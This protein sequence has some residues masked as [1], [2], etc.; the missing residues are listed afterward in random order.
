M[1]GPSGSWFF[2]PRRLSNPRI[3]VF[4]FPY[5]GGS[6]TLFRDWPKKLPEDIELTGVQLPGRA[7]RLKDPPYTQMSSLLDELENQIGPHLDVPFVFWGHSFGAL[8]AFELVRR[9]EKK[10]RALPLLVVLSGRRAPHLPKTG[11]DVRSMDD[12]E[13]I[14][15]LRKLGGTPE[16]IINNRRLMNLVLPA[17]RADFELLHQWKHEPGETLAVPLRVAG[18]KDDTPIKEEDLE[19]WGQYTRSGFSVHMFKGGHFYVHDAE[20][21]LLPW[22]SRTLANLSG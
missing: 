9:F 16:E 11:F 10:G 18:G 3:R 15:E 1:E 8:L 20:D 5:A 6:A 7:F 22:L 13:F 2:V 21:E 17:L 12:E 14:D 19:A 4:C